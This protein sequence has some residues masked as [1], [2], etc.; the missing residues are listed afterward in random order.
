MSEQEEVKAEVVDTKICE[1]CKKSI[2]VKKQ[3]RTKQPK[4]KEEQKPEEPK[5]EQLKTEEPESQKG[6]KPKKKEGGER[7]P[8]IRKELMSKIIIYINL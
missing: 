8:S 5:P 1:I 4:T 6:I 7:C 2:K 3:P